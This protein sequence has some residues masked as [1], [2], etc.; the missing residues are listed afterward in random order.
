MRKLIRDKLDLV[1]SAKELEVVR[2]T[3][4]EYLMLITEK[5]YEELEELENSNFDDIDEYADVIEVLIT[6]AK[7]KGISKEDIWARRIE[8]LYE[9]GGFSKGLVLNRTK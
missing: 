9:K 6:I 5:L 2:S 4:E 7:T 3:S 8:K 1:I